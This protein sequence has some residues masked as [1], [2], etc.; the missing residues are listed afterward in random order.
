METVMRFMTIASLEVRVYFK[1]YWRV[2]M[3][4]W[5]RK[6]KRSLMHDFHFC[7]DVLIPVLIS[8]IALPVS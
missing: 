8:S 6:E 3:F 7:T 1:N 2:K 4:I 5:R